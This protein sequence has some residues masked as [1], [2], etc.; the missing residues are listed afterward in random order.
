MKLSRPNFIG[1]GAH[2]AGTTWLYQAL[3][4]HQEIWLPPVKELHFFDRSTSYLNCPNTLATSSPL[5]RFLG[6][7]NW[8][9]PR[10]IRELRALSKRMQQGDLSDF[11]WW[12]R[13]IFG[14]YKDDWYKNLFADIG[15]S[16]ICGEITPAYAVLE[17]ED[18]A[19]IHKINPL[20]KLIYMIRNPI[21]RDW[22][23]IRFDASSGYLKLDLSSEDDII[24]ALQSSA[25]ITRGNYEQTIER[26]LQFFDS[27]QILVGFYD[28]ISHN[29]AGLMNVIATFLDI[30]PFEAAQIDNQTR[31]NM[32]P[33]L[34]MPD[35]VRQYLT[36]RYSPMLTRLGS[37]LGSYTLTWQNPALEIQPFPPAVHPQK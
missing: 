11:W 17:L 24:S 14:Y 25:I 7:R 27:S 33:P 19:K 15:D 37:S 16:K 36:E 5:K 21:E 18:I 9:R 8:E 35:R 23:A 22:S 1:I 34:I 12:W 6:S 31:I 26:Y 32:S 29:P 4:E 28:A 30:S 13:W 3:K 10:M 2:K 20:A